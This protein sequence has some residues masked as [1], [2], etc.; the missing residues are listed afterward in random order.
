[1]EDREPNEKLDLNLSI[2]DEWSES[3]ISGLYQNVLTIDDINKLLELAEEDV[4]EIL[5]NVDP[6]HDD[7]PYSEL[8]KYISKL[9]R[10]IIYIKYNLKKHGIN[11]NNLP[12]DITDCPCL[13]FDGICQELI[14]NSGNSDVY[15]CGLDIKILKIIKE[16]LSK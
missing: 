3:V 7:P 10:Q 13:D 1:M 2:I 12:I 9:L 5:Y 4:D 11:A 14:S 15:C 8:V 16:G 6:N